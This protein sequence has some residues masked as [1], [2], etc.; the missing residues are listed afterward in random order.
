MKQFVLGL[1]IAAAL[2]GTAQA[3]TCVPLDQ[4][5]VLSAMF[6]AGSQQVEM[7]K[8]EINSFLKSFNAWQKPTNYEADAALAV[9]FPSNKVVILYL[10]KNGSG[11]FTFTFAASDFD[12]L[13]ETI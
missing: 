13:M 12:K 10:F 8:D 1:M 6:Y 11:A 3:A 7:G 4:V 2:A 9:R 5:K